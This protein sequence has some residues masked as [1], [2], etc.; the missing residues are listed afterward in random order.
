MGTGF[1]WGCGDENIL[2]LVVV[3]AQL[4]E[5][6]K[7]HCIYIKRVNFMAWELYLKSIDTYLQI[8]THMNTHGLRI[9][10]KTLKSDL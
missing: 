8:C 1:F 4:R 10:S 5:H 6:A 9:S 7:K 2:E 3:V